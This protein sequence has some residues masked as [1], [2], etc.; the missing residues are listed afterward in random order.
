MLYTLLT[1]G[2]HWKTL[3]LTLNHKCIHKGKTPVI[4]IQKDMIL[5]CDFN[6]NRTLIDLHQMWQ[7]Y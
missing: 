7:S 6:D 1:M 2:K 5:F 3:R 4:V